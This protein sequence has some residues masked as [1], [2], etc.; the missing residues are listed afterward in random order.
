MPPY[1]TCSVE[2]FEKVGEFVPSPIYMAKPKL[3]QEHLVPAELLAQC[4]L[5]WDQKRFV[6]P[7]IRS[8]LLKNVYVSEQGLVFT[9]DGKVIV[10]SITNHG[11]EEI[12]RAAEKLRLL[13]TTQESVQAHE[14]GILCK[15][16]GAENYGHWLVEMLP[17][18]FLAQRQLA[19]GEAWP[20]IVHS[21]SEKMNAVV[22]ESLELINYP[23]NNIIFTNSEP[24]HFK[25]LILIDGL[26]VHSV[27][28]ST[29]VFECMETISGSVPAGSLERLYISR[30][31]STNRCF[32]N[33]AE[34]QALFTNY[35]YREVVCAN[36]SFSE[37]VS[38]FKAARRIAG[39]MGAAFTNAIFCQPDTS[40]LL[41]MPATAHEY[42]FWQIAEGKKIN[43]HEI[44]TQEVGP[45]R[46]PLPWD[47]D[48]YI[49]PGHLRAML[50]RLIEC[51]NL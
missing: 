43:Y 6:L 30:R 50:D 49:E 7:P 3:H 51:D 35:G 34:I 36:L 10:Q 32:E 27:F 21:S 39:P 18:A 25:E 19:L 46:G 16:R 17:K 1:E 28:M 44:R 14:R 31:P 40:W 48:L 22:R 33:E 9:E 20:A 2:I 12:V 26:T 37:Q 38:A 15:K 45:N 5:R 23:T 47:R 4:R 24:C 13:A 42:F 41:F 29:P 8:Y 11:Q